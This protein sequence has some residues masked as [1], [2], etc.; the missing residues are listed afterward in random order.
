MGT[1]ACG[2]EGSML[3]SPPWSANST[4][5]SDK[6]LLALGEFMNPEMMGDSCVTCV[7]STLFGPTGQFCWGSFAFC[8]EEGPD[9]DMGPRP[10]F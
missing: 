2:Q 9:E 1:A 3:G 8:K 4:L 7:V 10:Q 5:E 6:K